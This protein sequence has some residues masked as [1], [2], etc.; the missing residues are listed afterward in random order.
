MMREKRSSLRL[1]ALRIR[2]CDAHHHSHCAQA[3]P[4]RIARR[5]H[6]RPHNTD[7]VLI[8]MSVCLS[9][10]APRR[11]TSTAAAAAVPASRLGRPR[12]SQVVVEEVKVV[13][14]ELEEEPIVT[15]AEEDDAAEDMILL[16]AGVSEAALDA[17]ET[18]DVPMDADAAA[19]GDKKVQNAKARLAKR[20]KSSKEPRGVVFVG[21]IPFGFFEKQMRSFFSQFGAVTRLRLSRNKK[22]GRPKNYAFVEFLYEDVAKIVAETMD[23]YLM[24]GRMLKCTRG[25]ALVVG[26]PLTPL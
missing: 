5:H 8:C 26:R 14:P 12:R 22:T 23:K 10:M 2:A 4:A 3:L 20:N 24:S 17:A 19:E 18:A 7:H 6:R 1:L 25:R 11:P 13:E 9:H 16:S 21:H 15:I